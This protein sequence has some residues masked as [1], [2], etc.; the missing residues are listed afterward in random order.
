MKTFKQILTLAAL[1]A[2]VNTATAQ[3]P[4]TNAVKISAL[5]SATTP[6]AGTETLPIVQSGAT[7]ST[8]VSAVIFAATSANAS[9]SNYFSLFSASNAAAI[10][11]SSNYFALYSGSNAA[12]ITASSN[13]FALY[14]GSNAAAILASSNG[15]IARIAGSNYLTPAILAT[16]NF[17]S[18]AQVTATIAGA[19]ATA[20]AVTNAGAANF[21]SVTTSNL[22]TPSAA[23]N[24]YTYAANTNIVL[25]AN[26]GTFQQITLTTSSGGLT[27]NLTPTNTADG[28]QISLMIRN[29]RAGTLNVGTPS[30]FKIYGTTN[31]T[32]TTSANNLTFLNW[33]VISTNIIL[34]GSPL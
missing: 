15:V 8:T 19:L 33:L 10:T 31:Y 12:A 9:T 32:L 30:G 6:L 28:Q 29:N 4:L 16:S 17:Q 13:Y 23:I 25:D 27:V 20:G 1:A 5:T 2:L 34:S 24:V 3:N 26:A 14:S 22:V 18:G 7:K 11:A 21:S